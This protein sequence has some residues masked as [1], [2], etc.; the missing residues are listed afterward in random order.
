MLIY[1]LND[2]GAIIVLGLVI[3]CAVGFIAYI[4]YCNWKEKKKCN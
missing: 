1:T 3:I 2:I 4:K